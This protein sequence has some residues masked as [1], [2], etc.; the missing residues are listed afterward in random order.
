MDQVMTEKIDLIFADVDREDSPGCA[1]GIVQ[2]QELIYTRGFGMANL[3]C[4]TPIS[5]TSIFHV[6]SVS[7][8]FTCMAIL[9]GFPIK[10]QQ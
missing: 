5:S 10:A 4:G 2:D 1:V 7:K 6:A 8:Q 9:L 3:E